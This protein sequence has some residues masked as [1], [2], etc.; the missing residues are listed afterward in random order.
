MTL[1][2][3]LSWAFNAASGSRL[4]GAPALAA[5]RCQAMASAMLK[6]SVPSKVWAFCAHSAAMASWP[7]AR[8]ISSKRS[9]MARAAPLSRTLNSLNTVCNCAS[10]GSVANQ[11]R[12]RAAR[13]PDVGAE[14]APPVKPSNGCVSLTLG[15]AAALLKGKDFDS[16]A[17]DIVWCEGIRV[18]RNRALFS[19][20]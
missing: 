12:T 8:L 5:S 16:G 15:E 3:S 19:P 1:T 14:K 6:R 10:S 4:S 2:R 20:I 17:S 9:R 7:L 13:S 11:S 18:S